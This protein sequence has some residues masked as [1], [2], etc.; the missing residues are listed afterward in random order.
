MS[1]PPVGPVGPVGP[2]QGSPQ[3]PGYRQGPSG[4][5]IGWVGPPVAPPPPPSPLPE[6]PRA[7]HA[8]LRSATFRWWKPLVAVLAVG[9]LWIVLQTILTVP[10]IFA[11][12]G[13]E[14]VYR[15]GQL[16]LGPWVFLANNVG[17]ATA[18]PL[19][20]LLSWAFFGQRPRWASSIQ[21]G[22]RWGWFFRCVGVVVPFWLVTIAIEFALSPPDDLGPRW[23]TVLMVVGI[24]L[25]T[26]VQAAGEEYLLRGF[27]ARAV[28]SYFRVEWLGWAVSTVICSLV[29]MRLH[30]AAD[31][32]LNVFYVGF[33]VASSWMV[34]RTGGLEASCALHIVNNLLAE[35]TMPFSDFSGMMDRSVGTGDPTVLINMGLMVVVA[36]I[37]DRLARRRGL[38][39]RTAP[40]RRPTPALP[41]VPG[42]PGVPGQPTV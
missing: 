23:Y 21:G 17:I 25:T 35:V 42:G 16:R 26:P 34:W 6:Q 33:G 37:I 1:Q 5:P 2:V 20:L 22:F 28:G 24:L 7:Y 4:P 9:L 36:I 18:I 40:G 8:F 39:Q 29:F 19:V 31:P 13:F 30:M 3:G 10:A 41:G 27:L 12:G 11:D 15:D 14:A 32:W 38:P